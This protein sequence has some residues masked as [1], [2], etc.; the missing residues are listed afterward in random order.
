MTPMELTVIFNVGSI[1]LGVIAW[2]LSIWAIGKYKPW[3]RSYSYL[4]CAMALLLQL[5]EVRNRFLGGDYAAVEDT[6]MA[7]IIAAV[8]MMCVTVILNAVA[9][10][11]FRRAQRVLNKQVSK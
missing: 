5:F 2:L 11:K 8:M 9:L 6:I 3:K 1:A 10:F 4:L 7:V